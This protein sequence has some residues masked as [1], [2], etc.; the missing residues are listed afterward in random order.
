MSS[1]GNRID[2]RAEHDLAV[3]ERVT[4]HDLHKI[5]EPDADGAHDPCTHLANAHRIVAHCGDKLLYVE[6]IGWHVWGPPW[7][8]D[9]LAAR[10]TVQGLGK[11]IAK[12]AAALAEWVAQAADSD[13]RK[14]RE[15]AMERRF[16]WATESESAGCV[17]S[18]LKMAAPSLACHAKDLDTNPLLLGLPAGVLELGTGK[19]RG[20]RQEDRITKVAGCDFDPNAT[21]P[22]WARFI[23]EIMGDDT[24][25]VEYVQTLAGYA[26]SG[27]RGQHLLPILWGAGANGK[28]TFLG[29]LQASLGEYAGSGAP[30]LLI[31]RGGEQHP[32]ELA[33]LQGKRLV[34][35]SE[36][37]ETGRLN[38]ERAKLLTG[39]DAITARRMRQDFYTFQPSHLL[40]M[41]TN[42]RPRVTGTDE[43]VWRR[44]RL[45]PFAVTVPPERRDPDLPE[46]L[47]AELP[48]ILIWCWHGWQRYRREGFKEPEAVRAATGEYREASDVVGSFIAEC[49]DTGPGLTVAAGDLYHAY[50][51]WCEQSGERARSKKEFGTRLAERGYEQA[52]GGGGM[53]RWRGIGIADSD[54]SDVSDADSRLNAL[55]DGSSIGYTGKRVLAS[56]TSPASEAYRRRKWG[57]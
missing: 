5:A 34:I 44:L 52:R 15:K 17:E 41:Q 38:E 28:S 8:F 26:L 22:T 50:S 30:G 40:V 56:L 11:I 36:T 23:A 21:A 2:E 7:R 47:R 48:G 29:A 53:R 20:H 43:G 45:I 1:H 33:D 31:Q 13:E 10:R 42:H 32:T 49:C 39:G 55:R 18:S 35:C 46:K 54:A 24:A 12:E 16:K 25:L 27:Q 4:G 14:K 9:E 37:S 57:E 3:L 51:L 19:H 6:G